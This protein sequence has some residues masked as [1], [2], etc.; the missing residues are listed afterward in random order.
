MMR[1]VFQRLPNQ[2]TSL[3]YLEAFG[4]CRIE[5]SLSKTISKSRN[6]SFLL[7]DFNYLRD[8]PLG[9]AAH[10]FMH[11]KR[12]STVLWRS[13]LCSK[14]LQLFQSGDSAKGIPMDKE[15]IAYWQMKRNYKY[16]KNTYLYH[17]NF[18]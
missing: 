2:I 6:Q 8:C 11:F 10:F 16:Q 7:L 1:N 14:S 13:A 17:T 15:G 3:N 12:G 18:S 4:S 9:F 5:R